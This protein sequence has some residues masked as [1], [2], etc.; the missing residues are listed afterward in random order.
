MHGGDEPPLIGAIMAKETAMKT[1]TSEIRELAEVLL[2]VQRGIRD[3]VLHAFETRAAEDLAA[4]A[5]DHEGDTIFGIDKVGEEELLHLLEPH[6]A[7]FGGFELVAEGLSGGSVGLCG[8]LEPA[9]ARYRVIVDPIDG[10]RGLMYQKRSAWVLTGVAPNR[11][12]ATSL[13]DVVLAV[14]TEIPTRKQH[15]CDELFAIRGAGVRAERFDRLR[16]TRAKL[17]LHPSTATTI[18]QGYAAI[19]RFFPGLRDELAAID[20]A[21]IFE[22]LGP[23]PPG[24]ALCFEEQYASSGG[25]LYELACGHDRFVADLRPLLERLLTQR[26]MPKGLCC[27]P[28]DICTALIAEELGVHLTDATGAKLNAPLDLETDVA[29]VGYANDAI[30]KQLEPVLQKVLRQRGHIPPAP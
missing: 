20:D 22:V 23:S 25:Q 30:R 24:K 16:C 27:H 11:G 15:L 1:D 4:V 10:T 12:P 3:R 29:W 18:A 21:L 17:E 19:S 6:A 28:Y 7:R 5:E 14:Q 8:G 26:G 9:R 2:E 13:E